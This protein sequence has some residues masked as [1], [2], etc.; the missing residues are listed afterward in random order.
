M[1]VGCCYK[2]IGGK[3]IVGTMI[4][5]LCWSSFGIG[6]A[7]GLGQGFHKTLNDVNEVEIEFL[8]EHP[9]PY[10]LEGF[11]FD[12]LKFGGLVGGGCLVGLRAG[13]ALQYAMNM[14]RLGNRTSLSAM[15]AVR[16]GHYR[17]EGN[18]S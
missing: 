14:S 5:I 3:V 4:F 11:L 18:T 9:L 1:L 17:V 15:I 7:I 2:M 16:G 12:F 10:F 13:G 8:V 6:C